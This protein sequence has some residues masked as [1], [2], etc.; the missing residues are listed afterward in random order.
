G[1]GNPEFYGMHAT[2]LEVPYAWEP[3]DLPP[4]MSPSSGTYAI[5]VTLL[6]GTVFGDRRDYFQYFRDREPTARL[7]GSIFVYRVE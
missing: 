5:S 1:G 3:H 4:K 7:G 6:Q 2:M